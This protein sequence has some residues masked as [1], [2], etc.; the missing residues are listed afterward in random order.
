MPI[1]LQEEDVIIEAG[2]GV[3]F[4]F[5][6]LSLGAYFS[7]MEN[8]DSEPTRAEFIKMLFRQIKSW[9][10]VLNKDGKPAECN[11]ENVE[12]LPGLLAL[13]VFGL[14]AKSAGLTEDFAKNFEPLLKQKEAATA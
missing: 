11:Q 14:Y 13:T 7:K 2:D 1:T 6:P 12:K 9:E 5:A 3:K 4:T 10:G 8:M